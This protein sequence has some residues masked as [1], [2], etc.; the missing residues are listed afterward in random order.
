MGIAF[1]R[2]V[3]A[4][5]GSSSKYFFNMT[6]E[7]KTTKQKHSFPLIIWVVNMPLSFNEK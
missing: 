7:H 4:L 1:I 5:L 3:W 2:M 6:I